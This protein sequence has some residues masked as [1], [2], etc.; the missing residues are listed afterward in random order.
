V[1]HESHGPSIQLILGLLLV[2]ALLAL[3]A[4]RLAH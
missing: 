1:H 2:L 4:S 3:A